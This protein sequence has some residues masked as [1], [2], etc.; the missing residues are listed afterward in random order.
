[1]KKIILFLIFVLL[2]GNSFAADK[3]LKVVAATTFSADLMRKIGGDLVKVEFVAS[4]KFNIHFIQPTPSD[5]RKTAHADLF[6]F[7][8]LDLEAWA[9]PLLEAAGNPQLFRG[10]ER[11]LDLSP[12]VK[13]LNIPT[14]NMTRAAG[15]LH[16]FGNPHYTLNPENALIMAEN[17]A[18]K[19]SE[20]DPRHMANY[21]ANADAFEIKLKQKITEWKMMSV[22]AAGKEVIAYHE[23]LAYLANFMGFKSEMFLEPKPGIPPTPQH[24]AQLTEYAR[25]NHVNVIAVASYYP[26][27][28]V[29]KLAQKIGARVAVVIQSPGEI[30][31]TEDIFSFYEHNVRALA[32]ALR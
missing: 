32:E 28:S 18:A 7:Y 4:P 6:V 29:D 10:G 17:A 21:R 25:K 26:R 5:V 13:L 11:N 20:I 30:K 24:L 9:D 1:M 19:L 14:G 8:G 22:P 2:T 23:D 27:G 3:P 12:G 16:L 15:D 31:G